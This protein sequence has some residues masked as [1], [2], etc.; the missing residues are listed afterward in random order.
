MCVGIRSN[1]ILEKKSHGRKKQETEEEE[2]RIVYFS[3]VFLFP[4]FLISFFVLFLANGLSL[5]ACWNF[6]LSIC[7]IQQI[8]YISIVLKL[9]FFECRG[10]L[11]P[12]DSLFLENE[13]KRDGLS[14]NYRCTEGKQTKTNNNTKN[15]IQR[16]IKTR[17]KG[18]EKM[19]KRE[20]G[21]QGK[22]IN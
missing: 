22:K 5:I 2:K 3:W 12:A 13:E 9:S 15:N 10:N 1:K 6:V 11:R 18:K 8:N 21:R 14:N 4:I 7:V 17:R 16:E 20:R 19:G